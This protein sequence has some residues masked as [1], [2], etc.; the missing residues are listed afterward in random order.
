M[1]K[2]N[3][4]GLALWNGGICMAR[5]GHCRNGG[6]PSKGAEGKQNFGSTGT[7]KKLRQL[8]NL[9]QSSSWD[10]V[11]KWKRSLENKFR[12]KSLLSLGV[13]SGRLLEKE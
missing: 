12:S 5:G 2:Q 3:T 11:E 9:C 4:A 6:P 10:M 13:T 7:L 8:V 1:E